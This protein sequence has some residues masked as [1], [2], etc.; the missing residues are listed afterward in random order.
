MG[1]PTAS[2]IAAITAAAPSS[3][4]ASAGSVTLA[5]VRIPA[6]ST[7]VLATGLSKASRQALGREPT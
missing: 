6:R 4:K 1:S 7:N 3:R 5:G 2:T